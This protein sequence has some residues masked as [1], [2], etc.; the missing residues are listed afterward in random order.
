MKSSCFEEIAFRDYWYLSTFKPVPGKFRPISFDTTIAKEAWAIFEFRVLGMLMEHPEF[1]DLFEFRVDYFDDVKNRQVMQL[2]IDR[3]ESGLGI[4][5]FELAVAVKP[6]EELAVRVLESWVDHAFTIQ[7]FRV[8]Y[9]E[10]RQ[11][12][13]KRVQAL[14]ATNLLQN[15]DEAEHILEILNEVS[16]L[17]L[18]VVESRTV[19]DLFE[20]YRE[21]R[22]N[23]DE[24]MS[25]GEP[26]LDKALLGGWR[27]GFYGVAGRLKE[28]KTL[29][30][31]YMAHKLAL[32]GRRV[33]FVSYEMPVNQVVDRILAQTLDIDVN[34]IA[35][36]EL[37]FELNAGVWARDLVDAAKSRLPE[38]LI[39][40]QPS[41]NSVHGLRGLLRRIEAKHGVI[42]AVFVDYGQIMSDSG[43]HPSPA[44]ENAV[45]SSKLR[46]MSLQLD[47]TVVCA[48]QIKRQDGVKEKK[49]FGASDIALSDQYAKDMVGVFY[50]N[51]VHMPDV[52]VDPLSVGSELLLD[53]GTYRFG[54]PKAIRFRA[55]DKFARIEYLPW[56]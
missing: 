6:N 10:L 20:E 31:L 14:Q 53:L 43:R 45:I 2:I 39:V 16:S 46:A 1:Y 11:A 7:D 50:I 40:E 56:R 13:V 3:Y 22:R 4:G 36:D 51:R 47:L 26:A 12:Y 17:S 18:D 54:P 35:S 19:K 30:L 33:V 15:P 41:D 23:G 8:A 27:S 42:D 52:D 38:N 29:V 32:Q 34:K 49:R 25:T 37:D 44:V 5:R 48:L 28:G 55:Y 9:Q 24:F 21:A